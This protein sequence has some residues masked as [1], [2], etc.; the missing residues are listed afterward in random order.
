MAAK[1]HHDSGF[2]HG[3]K[4]PEGT[5]EVDMTNPASGMNWDNYPDNP[6]AIDA[7]TREEDSAM[8]KATKP[9]K[10]G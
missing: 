3:A 10:L 1:R 5:K 9:K 8:R 7:Y 6:K 2:G 4:F